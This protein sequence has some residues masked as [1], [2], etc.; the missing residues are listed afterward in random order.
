MNGD[1]MTKEKYVARYVLFWG[2]PIAA[3]VLNIMASI[4]W[5]AVPNISNI[6]KIDRAFDMGYYNGIS[7]IAVLSPII[8]WL[9]N[10]SVR[11]S[12]VPYRRVVF[13]VTAMYTTIFFYLL[14]AI[15]GLLQ[16][17]ALLVPSA[18]SWIR[19][20]GVSSEGVL[21]FSVGVNFLC[22]ASFLT[23]I[24]LKIRCIKVWS[25]MMA[26][27]Y[28]VV[29][30]YDCAK[31][32]TEQYKVLELAAGILFHLHIA[33]NL[34]YA[35]I[36]LADPSKV[37]FTWLDD[38]LSEIKA[39]AD[40]QLD[41]ESDMQMED[42]K[43]A[44]TSDTSK[45]TIHQQA[46]AQSKKSYAFISYSSK[47]QKMADAVRQLFIEKKIACWM[48]PYDIPAGSKYAYVI[49]DAL[50]NCACFVLLLTQAAQESQFVEREVER[51]ITY[52][53]PI[54]P[55]QLEEMQLNSG[56]KY[57]LGESQI[58]A[59]PDIRMDS[60]EFNRVVNGIHQ[61]INI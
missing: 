4:K 49:N 35:A 57:Y 61:F 32:E 48:A 8:L 29:L 18:S 20:L 5:Q 38:L 25:Y 16:G 2:L 36:I 54:V 10:K 17:R 51:A 45:S 34:Q 23:E 28:L 41:A 3:F 27:F 21:W 42:E 24:I 47:N 13:T 58:I 1:T 14:V 22:L 52:K 37:D 7:G 59:L 55:I 12:E 50:E 11:E 40:N 19:S 33:V 44:N 30:A 9:T 60:A 56:F 31:G 46:G 26:L 43:K 15:I 39:N 53:K 6:L